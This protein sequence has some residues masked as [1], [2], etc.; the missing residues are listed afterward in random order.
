ME[1]KPRKARSDSATQAVRAMQNAALPE[2]DP[3]SHV[4]LRPEDRPFWS[5]I[6][7]ARARDDWESHDLVVAAQLA[8]TQRD[9][10]V[11]SAQLEAEGTV[12]KNDRGTQVMNPRVTV[13]EQL[14]RREMALMR[15]LRM[16]GKNAG[17]P[18]DLSG[19]K[20]VQ[21][22]AQKARQQVED[23]EDLLA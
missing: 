6:L 21:K 2:L 5:G 7:C 18:R 19:A 9:I 16:G 17:D 20:N 11:E 10:E 12:V 4:R 22:G 15:T 1:K 13:L 8:R 14:A 3:P 23:E